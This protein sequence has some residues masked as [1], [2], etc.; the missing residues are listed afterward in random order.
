M[1]GPEYIS[2]KSTTIARECILFHLTNAQSLVIAG[3]AKDPRRTIPRA[4]GT[5]IK[6]LLI[7]FIGGALCVGVRLSSLN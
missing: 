4:F 6:R 7:F 2:S 3:E 5:I 1:A